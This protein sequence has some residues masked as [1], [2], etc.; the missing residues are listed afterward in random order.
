LE[1]AACSENPD[2]CNDRALAGIETN[3]LERT[4]A[5]TPCFKEAQNY[6]LR[7]QIRHSRHRS[8]EIENRAANIDK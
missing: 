5:S 4:L 6:K 1:G 7:K 3:A 8:T 2:D